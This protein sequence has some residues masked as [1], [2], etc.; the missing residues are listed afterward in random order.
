MKKQLLLIIAFILVLSG[1]STKENPALSDAKPVRTVTKDQISGNPELN[2]GNVLFL[3][4]LDL[5]IDEPGVAY[6]NIL[7]Q[8]ESSKT[9]IIEKNKDLIIAQGYGTDKNTGDKI[10]FLKVVYHFQNGSLIRGPV[11]E[12]TPGHSEFNFSG[13]EIKLN[14][15]EN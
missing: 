1:C 6:A 10:P 9:K 2:M 15:D 5:P 4:M 7:E 3:M 12:L 13:S 8:V 11:I 14:G